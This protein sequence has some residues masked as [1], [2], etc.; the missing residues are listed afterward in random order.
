MSFCQSAVVKNSAQDVEQLPTCAPP[1]PPL[2][3]QNQF[4][5]EQQ[6]GRKDG[7]REY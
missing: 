5:G 1:P 3:L 2:L 7:A 6:L 4:I